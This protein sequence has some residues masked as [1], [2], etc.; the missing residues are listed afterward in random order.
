MNE[1]KSHENYSIGV[2]ER[3]EQEVKAWAL[4]AAR[5]SASP[6]TTDISTPDKFLKAQS[7]AICDLLNDRDRLNALEGV[8]TKR[9]LCFGRLFS[10]EF[11]YQR[12]NLSLRQVADKLIADIKESEK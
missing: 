8:R 5:V 12:T 6:A 7:N 4:A 2:V 10:F 11:D 1:E 3:L 9:I